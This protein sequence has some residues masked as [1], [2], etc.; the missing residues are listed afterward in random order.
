CKFLASTTNTPPRASLGTTPASNKSAAVVAAT[1]VESPLSVTEPDTAGDVE[2]P[3]P[4]E[5]VRT[6]F[7]TRILVDCV[8]E[9]SGKR[10]AAQ[11]HRAGP[12]P[13]RLFRSDRLELVTVALIGEC[14]IALARY[15]RSTSFVHT[16][17]GSGPKSR[18]SKA[19]WLRR[20]AP[21]QSAPVRTPEP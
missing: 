12:G 10:I 16:I 6:A 19:G 7:T 21:S 4:R 13:E 15:Q 1:L 11:H 2:N 17:R 14:L 3:E 20:G 18:T 9:I 5:T 8:S